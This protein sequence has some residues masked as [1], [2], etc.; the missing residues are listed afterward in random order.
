MCWTLHTLGFY[1]EINNTGNK[2]GAKILYIL[3]FETVR[4]IL[5]YCLTSKGY[6]VFGAADFRASYDVNILKGGKL[7]EIYVY[8]FMMLSALCL[9]IDYDHLMTFCLLIN[10][11]IYLSMEEFFS[12]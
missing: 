11:M 9:A 3:R 2:F 7:Y 10:K 8:Y 6:K 1:E 4:E 12:Y 5:H